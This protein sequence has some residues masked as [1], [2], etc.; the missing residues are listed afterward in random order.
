M[1]NKITILLF[2]TCFYIF[3]FVNLKAEAGQIPRF[4]TLRANEVNMR[5]GP[6]RHYPVEWVYTQKGLPLKVVA[7]FHHWRKVVDFEGTT[8]WIH[9]SLLT[10]RKKILIRHVD[11]AVYKTTSHEAKIVGYLK[12]MVIV[13]LDECENHWCYISIDS[14][15]G[16]VPVTENIWGNSD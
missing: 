7:E 3:S 5:A 12:P 8:G 15:S 6:G 1:M 14:V 13:N 11:Q 4:V 16:W 2:I 9:K 10:G